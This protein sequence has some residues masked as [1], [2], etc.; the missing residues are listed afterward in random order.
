MTPSFVRMSISTSGA[1]GIVPIAV[2]S[3]RAKGAI[4]GRATTSRIVSARCPPPRGEG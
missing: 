2:R 1:A 4:T 3:G